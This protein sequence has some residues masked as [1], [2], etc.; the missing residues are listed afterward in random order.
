MH[1]AIK[2]SVRMSIPVRFMGQDHWYEVSVEH[3]PGSPATDD[4]PGEDEHSE[5]VAVWLE[6]YSEPIPLDALTEDE[7]ETLEFKVLERMK[8]EQR[9]S[10]ADDR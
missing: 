6:G 2:N 4:S 8:A 7:R 1:E 3:N 5:I 10:W 9:R